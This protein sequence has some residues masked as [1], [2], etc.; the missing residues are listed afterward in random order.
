MQK[1]PSS[2]K[3]EYT[4]AEVG[5]FI[6]YKQGKEWQGY[7]P[8]ETRVHNGDVYVKVDEPDDEDGSTWRQQGP[9]PPSAT[10]SE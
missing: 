5:S 1:S 4:A 3:F 9:L 10:D 7:K 8:G 2:N 6:L